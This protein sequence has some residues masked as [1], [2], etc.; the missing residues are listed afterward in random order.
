[1]QFSSFA[2]CAA[3]SQAG[4]SFAAQV[5]IAACVSSSVMRQFNLG[6]GILQAAPP[7]RGPLPGICFVF[8]KRKPEA[9]QQ[10]H[11]RA[12]SGFFSP[13]FTSSQS[14]CSSVVFMWTQ[15]IF[16]PSGAMARAPRAPPA[17]IG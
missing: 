10:S 5:V 17:R 11:V 14:I 7:R 4:K 1:V 3:S 8:L 13:D 6:I 2:T 15:F 9:Q 12:E 16:K